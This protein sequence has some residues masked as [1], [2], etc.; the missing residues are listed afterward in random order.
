[1][2]LTAGLQ[3]GLV[4]TTAT[5][6]DT[7]GGT[8]ARGNGGLGARGETDTG[9]A[10]LAVTNDGGIVARGTGQRS[11]VANLFL[12]VADNGTFGA[13]RDGQDVADVQ[14]RLLA[15]VD[16]RAGREA[17]GG[18][19]SLFAELVAVGVTEDDNGEG[20]ATVASVL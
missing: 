10:V 19:E 18:D 2:V 9:L 3:E 8:A 13:L 16:E 15:A 17:F 6:D 1:V 5:G 4:D 11:T 20:S 7:D 14:G 12:D